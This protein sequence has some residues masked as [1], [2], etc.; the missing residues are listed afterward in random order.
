LVPKPR[1]GVLLW[2]K[3]LNGSPRERKT[4]LGRKGTVRNVRLRRK[5]E[6][7]RRSKNS[8]PTGGLSQVGRVGTTMKKR[9]PIITVMEKRGKVAWGGRRRR[10]AGL[11]HLIIKNHSMEF[12]SQRRYDKKKHKGETKRVTKAN[13]FRE[14]RSKPER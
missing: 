5:S 13:K 12:N 11:E 7:Q 14:I 9:S 3:A 8:L 2:E 4:N 1:Q 10:K 6:V